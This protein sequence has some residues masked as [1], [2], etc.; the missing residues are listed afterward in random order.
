MVTQ[1]EGGLIARAVRE[2]LG[3][4]VS[5]GMYAQ[6]VQ[7]ALDASALSEIP[8]QGRAVADWIAGPL[9]REV[10][11]A[12]GVDAAE[13]VSAQLAP[14][15]AH[16]S[17]PAAKAAEGARRNPFG[18][19]QPTGVA[20]A[21]KTGRTALSGARADSGLAPANARAGRELR[22]DLARTARIKLSPE[23]LAKLQRP[24][25]SD[26]GHTARPLPQDPTSEHA[27][28]QPRLLLGASS[29]TAALAG[30][31]QHLG[32]SASVI[33]IGDLVGLL[34][35]LEEPGVVEPIVLLDCRRPTVHVTSI[36]AI[37]ED[38]PRG[39]SIVLW[40]ASDD[41][42]RELDR[43]RLPNVR[44]VRC[45]QEATPADVAALCAMVLRGAGS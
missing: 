16:A 28:A 37:G 25:D 19:E 29:D 22:S 38:L 10:E 20:A 35:A 23:Q 13:L 45:S 27:S 43:D 36:A 15:V 44:W 3:T 30:L 2:A 17:V 6:L 26:Q 32:A 8:E 7:R 11:S 1:K 34:D 4:L 12:V 39:T 42:W 33:A 14:I 24:S 40:G 21:P 41:A 9:L 5:P 31:A 18:S